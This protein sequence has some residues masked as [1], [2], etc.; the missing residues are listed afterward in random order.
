LPSFPKKYLAQLEKSIYPDW[1]S[2]SF[3]L[4]CSDSA[5]WGHYG[6]KHKG[7]CLKFKVHENE[8]NFEINFETEYGYSSGPIIG[9]RP[10]IFRKVEYTTK[11]IEIDFFRSIG[12]L[13]RGEL[14]AMWYSD[15]N[16]NLAFV[17]NI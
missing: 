10:H 16:G 3:L 17:E 12:R 13:N 15:G 6:D 1:Y 4:E 2:A 7:V 9:M 8:G 14:N 5:I 11:H